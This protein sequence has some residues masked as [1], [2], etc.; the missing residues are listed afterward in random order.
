M[1]AQDWK[2]RVNDND[3]VLICGDLCWAMKIEN[4]GCLYD[5][6]AALPGKKLSF[7]EITIIG[8]KA[9]VQFAT[10]CRQGAMHFKMMQ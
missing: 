10:F 1:I 6:L 9:L 5:Y 7:E 8:G 4:A 2:S 3:V